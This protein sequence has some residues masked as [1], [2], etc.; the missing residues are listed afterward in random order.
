MKKLIK[1]IKSNK[2]LAYI[3]QYNQECQDEN[4]KIKITPVQLKWIKNVFKRVL[5][6][7]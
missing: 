6:R 2:E 1:E 3:N 5:F 7:K 4:V